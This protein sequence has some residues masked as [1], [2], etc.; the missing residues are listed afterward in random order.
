MILSDIIET[1]RMIEILALRARTPHERELALNIGEL[2]NT[3]SPFRIE[4]KDPH[5]QH[6]ENTGHGY[7]S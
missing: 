1:M 2:E 3:T 6:H 7:K 5:G 4:R